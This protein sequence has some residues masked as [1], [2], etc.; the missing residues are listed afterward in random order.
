MQD[1][2]FPAVFGT[3]AV[4]LSVPFYVL[5]MRQW[6]PFGVALGVSFSALLQVWMLYALWNRRS[7]NPGKKHV[8]QHVGKM[9]LISTLLGIIL[10]GTR[11][12]VLVGIN[13]WTLTGA[14]L[15]CVIL[16]MLFL[17]LLVV[18]GRVMHMEEVPSLFSR[19]ADQVK[20][21]DQK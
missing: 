9:I 20:E 12:W 16:G 17:V 5:G 10:E 11:R 13:P 4:A 8:Y 18:G 15:L 1:T 7:P 21:W 14:L 2:L 19:L 6:G 3:V